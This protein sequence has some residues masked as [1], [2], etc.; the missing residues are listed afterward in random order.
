MSGQVRRRDP[1]P[2]DGGDRTTRA[3]SAWTTRS[4]PASSTAIAA[5]ATR[6]AS[7]LANVSDFDP[8]DG[9][10][11]ATEQL[12]E[13]DR[14]RAGPRR[15]AAGRHPGP[16]R[17]LRV[18]T[19]SSSKLQV[20]CSEDLGAFYLGRAEGP[21]LHD[22]AQEPGA[23]FGANGAVA[24]HAR[25]AALDGAFP[26]LHGRGGLGPVRQGREHLRRDLLGLR[27]GGTRACWRNGSASTR[28]ATK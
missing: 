21:P 27:F 7:L 23:P 10:G 26:Q 19:P 12:L 3:T 5:C 13:V 14:L 16:L 8:G 11:R 17:A 4:S 1:A 15:R 18:S 28:S 24:D 9:C 6:C 22:R 25:H 2:V 20:Y